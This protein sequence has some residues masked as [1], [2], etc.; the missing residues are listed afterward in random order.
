M[1]PCVNDNN[2]LCLCWQ[3]TV[4]WM[5]YISIACVIVYVIGHAIGP[6]ESAPASGYLHTHTH[7]LQQ[8]APLA[9]VLFGWEQPCN[10]ICR[11]SETWASWLWRSRLMMCLQCFG[12]GWPHLWDLSR[13]HSLC[14]DHWDVQAVGQARRLHGRRL[15]PLALQ[16]HCW[17]HLPL[18]RGQL[19]NF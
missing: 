10:N 7:W 19:H 5:P 15:R 16:L 2:R 18:P 12:C 1:W 3:E 4:T 14:G 6:S 17:P 13:S 8:G 9:E 11:K